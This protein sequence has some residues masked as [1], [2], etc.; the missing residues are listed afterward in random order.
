M[1][2]I[3]TACLICGDEK[4]FEVTDEQFARFEIREHVQRIFPEL[5]DDDRERLIS[6][7]CPKCWD[8]IFSG[9]EKTNNENT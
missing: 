6:G 3:H 5:S 9:E 4:I 7:T 1:K 8:E 2:H